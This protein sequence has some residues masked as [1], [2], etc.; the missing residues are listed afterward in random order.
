MDVRRRLRTLSLPRTPT[1]TLLPRPLPVPSVESVTAALRDGPYG[2]CVYECD[3]DVCD[4]QVVNMEF[5]GGRT[6]SFTLSAF[7]QQVCQ[8]STRISG[9]KC[10]AGPAR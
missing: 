2:R 9:T 8:R 3:N 1:H 10:E 5:E 7:T 6:A 4:N